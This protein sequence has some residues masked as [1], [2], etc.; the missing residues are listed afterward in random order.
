VDVA[1]LPIGGWGPKVGDG[2]LDG[3]EAAEAAARIRPQLVIPIHWGTYLRADLIGRRPELL[4][5][6][7]ELLRESVAAKAPGVE[8]RVLAPGERVEL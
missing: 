6:P 1:L 2:H 8:V 3:T 4:S 7:P 5:R